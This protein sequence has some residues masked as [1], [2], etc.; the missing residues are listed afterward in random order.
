MKPKFKW[1]ANAPWITPALVR[2]ARGLLGWSQR[3][4]AHHAAVSLSTVKRF[5]ADVCEPAPTTRLQ[6]LFAFSRA[7]IRFCRTGREQDPDHRRMIGVQLLGDN[8]H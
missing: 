8:Y 6:I 1:Q 3:E 7:R 5:E 2:A 4:L